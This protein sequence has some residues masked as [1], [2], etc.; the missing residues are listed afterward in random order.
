[1]ASDAA[2]TMQ[3]ACRAVSLETCQAF[4]AT[5]QIESQI[6][7]MAHWHHHDDR[8][9]SRCQWS[10]PVPLHPPLHR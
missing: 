6:M 1:M 9:F 10:V 7:L 2:D 8:S 3:G 5:K 4:R